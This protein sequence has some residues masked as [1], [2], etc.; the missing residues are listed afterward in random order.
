MKERK[1]NKG[2]VKRAILK[3]IGMTLLIDIGVAVLFGPICIIGG[4]TIEVI[5]LAC[6]IM[7]VMDIIPMYFYSSIYIEQE[8]DKVKAMATESIFR[9]EDTTV[10][11]PK[12]FPKK[13]HF[14]QRKFFQEELPKIADY[15]ANLYENGTI[16]IVARLKDGTTVLHVENISKE[17]FMDS[18]DVLETTLTDSLS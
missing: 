18:Y 12:V 2:A 16:Q 6:W 1:K 14:K 17:N 5:K 11:Y 3:A 15:Y 10:V 9:K 13:G 7:L 8:K 4:E